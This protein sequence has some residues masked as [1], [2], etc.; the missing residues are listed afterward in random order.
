MDL[1]VN[2]FSRE[3]NVPLGLVVDTFI[4]HSTPIPTI[5]GVISSDVYDSLFSYAQDKGDVS[6]P[7]KRKQNNSR[8]NKK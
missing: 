1:P 6:Y 4:R 3:N 2:K 5:S 8:K 7:P